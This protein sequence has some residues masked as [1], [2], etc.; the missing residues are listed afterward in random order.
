MAQKVPVRPMPALQCTTIGCPDA[1][2]AASALH[3][4]RMPLLLSGVPW[5]GQAWKW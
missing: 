2:A 4:A 1:R 3:I 5:S